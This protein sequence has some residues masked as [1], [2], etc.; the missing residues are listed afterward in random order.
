MQNVKVYSELNRFPSQRLL[1]QG[2]PIYA[3]WNTAFT[4]SYTRVLPNMQQPITKSE[5]ITF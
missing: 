4:N 3:L 1:E 5:L 2:F